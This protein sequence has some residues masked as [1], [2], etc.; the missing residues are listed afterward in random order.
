MSC[1]RTY[2][3]P[4][5]GV[6]LGGRSARHTK[7]GE[8][9]FFLHLALPH[10]SPGY[11]GAITTAQRDHWGLITPAFSTKS[12]PLLRPPPRLFLTS[13]VS[14]PRWCSPNLMLMEDSTANIVDSTCRLRTWWS[15]TS[16]C[17]AGSTSQIHEHST[18]PGSPM[19]TFLSRRRNSNR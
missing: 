4:A 5:A 3:L 14:V 19:A 10:P 18:S 2:V 17:V 15:L 6:C 9:R 16:V 13:E 1:Q 8:I 7:D 11:W 12:W